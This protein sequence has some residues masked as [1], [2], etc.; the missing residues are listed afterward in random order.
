MHLYS[1]I[2]SVIEKK[3][4]K[5]EGEKEGK[6]EEKK[7]GEQK[8]KEK[9]ERN[10]EILAL[11]PHF[12]SFPA[13]TNTG[14]FQKLPYQLKFIQNQPNIGIQ[15]LKKTIS[16]VESVRVLVLNFPSGQLSLLKVKSSRAPKLLVRNIS[17]IF[18]ISI[19][20]L[21][22]WKTTTLLFVYQVLARNPVARI[23]EWSTK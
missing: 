9:K 14:F 18:K 3:E 10:G 20:S 12:L 11:L 13:L 19:F 15:T 22:C 6:K 16:E 23:V 8:R 17:N 1:G 7:E 2:F 5:K 21:S 4:E